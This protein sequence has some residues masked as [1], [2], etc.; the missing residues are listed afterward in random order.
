MTPGDKWVLTDKGRQR[1][2][3]GKG[4]AADRLE[5]LKRHAEN[6]TNDATP[7]ELLGLIKQIEAAR[8]EN[9]TLR[10]ELALRPTRV[11]LGCGK[12]HKDCE[13][14]DE[15]IEYHKRLEREEKAE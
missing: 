4:L 2:H 10:S 13:C 1:L 15:Q 3:A 7:K 9:V 11:C 6:G 8:A 12:T 14:T 5:E